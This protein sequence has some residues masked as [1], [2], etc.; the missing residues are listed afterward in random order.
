MDDRTHR[1]V[2]EIDRDI[3]EQVERTRKLV[4]SERFW[5]FWAL[6]WTVIGLVLAVLALAGI[7]S[8]A[9]A[10]TTQRTFEDASGRNVGRSVTDGRGNS[11]YYDSMGRNTGRSTSDSQGNRAVYDNMGRRTGTVRSTR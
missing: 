7:L 5:R 11:T 9:L 4:E 8:R 2:R 1:I 10:Q 3:A 6:A